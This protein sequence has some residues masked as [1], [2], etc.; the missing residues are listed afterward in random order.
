MIIKLKLVGN[1]DDT[2]NNKNI[3]SMEE[4]IKLRESQKF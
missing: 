4:L 1:N 3:Q 2:K